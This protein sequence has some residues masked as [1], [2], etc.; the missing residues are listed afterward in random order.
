MIANLTAQDFYDLTIGSD[1]IT[2]QP[3]SLVNFPAGVRGLNGNDTVFGSHS[4]E[5]ING[6]A[7][8]DQLFGARENDTLL[9][10]KDAD[11]LFGGQ[12]ND[13]LNGN[14]GSD[15]VFGDR[16]NDTV[17]GGQGND[18]LTG[19]EG[20]DVLIG[21][22]G[23]DTLVGGAGND[24]FVLRTDTALSNAATADVIADFTAGSDRI[25]LT[26][27]LTAA[28]LVLQTRSLG[29]GRMDTL[30]QIKTTGL[31]LGWV[32]NTT[33]ETLANQFIAA[34][35]LL[36]NQPTGNVVRSQSF[37]PTPIRITPDDLPAP[38]ATQSAAKSPQVVPVPTDATLNV[39]PGFTVN[40][41]AENLNRPR[42]LALTPTG[43]LLVT[44]TPQNQIRL[45]RDTDGNGVADV[46]TIF[47]SAANGLNQPFGMAF[48]ENAFFVGN[49]G[50]VLRFPYTPGQSAIAGT[51]ENIADLPT[52]GHWTRNLAIDPN[53]QKLYVSI[54]S[55]SNV[56]AEP[57]PRAS[58]QVMNLDGSNQQTFAFGLRN[59]VG[60]D[61]QPITGK[62]YTTVNERD[63]LGDDL[64][65]DY[66]TGLNAGD[67][68]GWPYA[69]LTPNK[70]DPRRAGER[71]DLVAQTRTP[72]VLFQ[73]H[74]A[75]LGLQFYDGSTFP[76]EYQNGA[77]VAFRGSWNRDQGTGYKIVFAP[78]DS[79]GNAE[80]YYQDF[81]TGFLLDPSVP[82]TWGRPVGL[83]VMPD[84]SLLFTD[85]G[86]DRI[87]RVQYTGT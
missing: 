15:R 47:A 75:P 49:T 4:A 79:A 54:G 58:V 51:G 1:N 41:F 73:A 21:D 2:L 50:E 32:L 19:G 68:Y 63:G 8:N 23:T 78:F 17:R 82:T 67:F 37:S 26:Q 24:I 77:F 52:G 9:G 57:L 13:I 53:T 65:P 55:A 86:S 33:P 45:L 42:W 16:G 5:M 11:I 69:Y 43:D 12:D 34:D 87:Y 64:V 60:L 10:G 29:T 44:E 38:F 70:V 71:P 62:L 14:K 48:T 31:F 39:P 72:D 18:E 83:Q 76:E 40:V 20:N 30:I 22:L 80:G 84:G 36:G 6:N 28:D 46:N 85:E 61:F 66:L 74:S 35:R 56:D 81:L 7:G 25:G 27:N 59:P 3:D